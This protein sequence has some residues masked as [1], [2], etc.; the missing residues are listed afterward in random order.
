MEG[1]REKDTMRTIIRALA[2]V[3]A[4]AVPAVAFAA[5][6]NDAVVQDHTGKVAP[7]HHKAKH[8]RDHAKAKDKDKAKHKARHGKHHARG[9]A[10]AR[11]AKTP[12]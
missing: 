3:T 2:L 6:N 5:P 12:K 1:C 9:K 11:H 4:L 8:H 7:K 10:H